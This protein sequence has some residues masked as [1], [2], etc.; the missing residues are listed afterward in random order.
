[1]ETIKREKSY[2]KIKEVCTVAE[3]KQETYFSV[4]FFPLACEEG[5]SISII[6]LDFQIY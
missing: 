5:G 1:M 3:E 4:R 6:S 2:D